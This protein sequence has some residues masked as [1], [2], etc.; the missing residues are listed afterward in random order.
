MGE[1]KGTGRAPRRRQGALSYVHDTQCVVYRG[2]DAA[3]R[4]KEL[5]FNS[6]EDHFSVVDVTDKLLPVQISLTPYDDVHYAHQ[7]W[8][9]DDQSTFLMGDELDETDGGQKKTRTLVFDVTDLDKPVVKP[10]FAGRTAAIDHNMY[11]R[12]GLVYQSNYA[13]GLAVLGTGKPTPS[14]LQEVAFFDSFP[15]HDKPEFVGSWSNYPYFASGTVAWSGIDDG[16]FLG[17]VQP[18]VLAQHATKK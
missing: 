13:A 18:Q 16:L 15:E 11:V 3:H 9:T 17:K 14:G 6:S 4:G 5:C 12:D 1:G 8:L 10:S 2:P 7:G